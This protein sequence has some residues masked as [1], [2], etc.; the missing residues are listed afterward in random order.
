[1]HFEFLRLRTTLEQ[2]PKGQPF[3]IN[4]GCQKGGQKFTVGTM[5]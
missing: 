3:P 4:H 2:F 5:F 1:M